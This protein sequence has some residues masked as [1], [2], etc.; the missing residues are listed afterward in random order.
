MTLAHALNLQ[1]Y[2]PE[3][4]APQQYRRSNIYDDPSQSGIM[5]LEVASEFQ[6]MRQQI[7]PPLSSGPP[8]TRDAESE[9]PHVDSPYSDRNT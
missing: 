5:A 7:P 1:V 4:Q 2:K 3:F 6:A 9:Y 8:V